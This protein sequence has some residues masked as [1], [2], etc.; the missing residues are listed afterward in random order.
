MVDLLTCKDL[1]R[2]YHIT[3][4]RIRYLARHRG[5]GGQ[6]WP[7][8]A[9]LFWPEDVALMKPGKPGSKPGPRGPRKEKP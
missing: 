3:P 9:W 7:G 6:L 1:A 5:I 4:R 2:I 8:G